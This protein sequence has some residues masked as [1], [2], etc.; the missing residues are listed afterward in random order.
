MT[1]I[2]VKH[3]LIERDL[4]LGVKK[5]PPHRCHADE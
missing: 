1:G 4:D 5:W 2:H 3:L